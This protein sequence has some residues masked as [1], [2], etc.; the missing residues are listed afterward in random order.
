MPHLVLTLVAL[1]AAWAVMRAFQDDTPR[2]PEK[3]Q[4]DKKS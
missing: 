3:T 2:L 1:T 4:S